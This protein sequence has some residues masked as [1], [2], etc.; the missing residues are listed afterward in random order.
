MKSSLYGS[1]KGMLLTVHVKPRSKRNRIRFHQIDDLVEV[2]LTEPA[3]DG[4]AN[5]ELIKLLARVLE[6]RRSS[7][8]IVEGA[9][10]RTKTVLIL[11]LG[12][13]EI[14]DHV[15]RAACGTLLF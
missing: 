3:Q 14:S 13:Q 7:I 11:G 9:R 4:R 1:S 6:V 15:A 2:S 8:L 10:S 12:K 5:R